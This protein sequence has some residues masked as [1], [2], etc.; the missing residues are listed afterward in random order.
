MEQWLGGVGE[1]WIAGKFSNKIDLYQKSRLTKTKILL[2]G[3]GFYESSQKHKQGYNGLVFIGSLPGFL[4]T[5]LLFCV[6]RY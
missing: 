4:P 1:D 5:C 2:K 3:V 6:M